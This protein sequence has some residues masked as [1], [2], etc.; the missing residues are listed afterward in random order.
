MSLKTWNEQFGLSSLP[1][2]VTTVSRFREG[3]DLISGFRNKTGA[4]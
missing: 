1:P 3:I 2:E 4:L